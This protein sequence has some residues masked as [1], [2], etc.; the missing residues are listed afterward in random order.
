[1]TTAIAFPT[2]YPTTE[3]KPRYVKAVWGDI[4]TGD[5]VKLAKGSF[6]HSFTVD[7]V[8]EGEISGRG[9]YFREAD[10][11]AVERLFTPA[12]VT[13]NELWGQWEYAIE[14]RLLNGK[15]SL[16]D[17][18]KKYVHA[19]EYTIEDAAARLT[20]EDVI[21]FCGK[22]VNNTLGIY[23]IARHTT[24]AD[25]SYVAK[26][27][28][29]ETMVRIIAPAIEVG[30]ERYTN[31]SNGRN[32][33]WNPRGATG[34]IDMKP[35]RETFLKLGYDDKKARDG[36]FFTMKLEPLFYWLMYAPFYDFV[37]GGWHT[38]NADS[39]RTTAAVKALGFERYLELVFA[40]SSIED[41]EALIPVA[42]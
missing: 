41:I 1:M 30:L 8:T 12:T 10:N 14:D 9:A 21:E 7:S 36:R 31:Y 11:W 22:D 42:A 16:E 2:T 18:E 34:F 40:G 33:T 3:A 13:V 17:W 6:S 27:V 25:F 26:L 32:D 29:L 4:A 23:A 24:F 19:N 28:G 5:S 38:Q 37:E 39:D 20:L 15:V 35:S